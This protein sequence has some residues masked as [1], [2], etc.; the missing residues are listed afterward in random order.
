MTHVLTGAPVLTS[1]PPAVVG[2]SAASTATVP[3]P[4]SYVPAVRVRLRRVCYEP[5][6]GDRADRPGEAGPLW[7]PG[8][9]RSVAAPV[10][11]PGV[12]EAVTR[13]LRTACEVLDGRRPPQHLARHVDDSVLRYWRVAAS[14]RQVRSPARFNRLR[15]DHP[16]ADAAEVAVAVELDG[17]VRALAARFDRT[18][19][20]RW[21]WTAV[22]LG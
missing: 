14:R 10:A 11:V 20:A 9:T 15:I 22:R 12:Q 18:D 7:C 21:L 8:R 17:R 19:D 13:I 16:H 5:R 3:G 6:P 2:P 4:P 1:A